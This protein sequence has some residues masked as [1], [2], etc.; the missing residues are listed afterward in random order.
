MTDPWKSPFEDET[1]KNRWAGWQSALTN[2]KPPNFSP[3]TGEEGSV[4]GNMAGYMQDLLQSTGAQRFLSPTAIARLRD[5]AMRV[6]NLQQAQ[7]MG[8]YGITDAPA[9]PEYLRNFLQQPTMS[10]G[11]LQN[12]V[13][14]ILTK[15]G[16]PGG[17]R[18]WLMNSDDLEGPQK[19]IQSLLGQSATG[20]SAVARN[21]QTKRALAEFPSYEIA[22]NQRGAAPNWLEY[23]LGEIPG[24]GVNRLGYTFR[25]PSQNW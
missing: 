10:M 11:D 4:Y 24:S 25:T 13:Q 17:V 9:D 16:Q 20:L 15:A 1:S 14:S 19:F 2:W 7:A 23:V 18:D 22:A 3:A 6:A 12:R 5:Q 21:M 8:D